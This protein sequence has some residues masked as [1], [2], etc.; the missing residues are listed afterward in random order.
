LHKLIKALVYL[1]QDY[2]DLT[3]RVS[4]TPLLKKNKSWFDK[5]RKSWYRH[6]LHFLVQNFGL[7]DVVV[8]IG[9]ADTSRMV[10]EFQSAHVS[11]SCSSI[12]NSSN[13]IGEAQLI[14]TPVIASYVGGTPQMLEHGKAGLLYRFDSIPMLI[15]QIRKIFDSDE[16]ATNQSIEGMRIAEERHNRQLIHDNLLSTYR[17]VIS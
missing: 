17:E 6:Y 4:G 2:P 5:F 1:K 13:S 3:L 9:L 10:H 8:F 11:I 7:S 15:W 12:E 14:G 16:F